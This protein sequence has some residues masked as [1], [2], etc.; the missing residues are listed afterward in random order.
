MPH[1]VS[2]TDRPAAPDPFG[3]VGRLLFRDDDVIVLDKPV[4]VAVHKGPKGGEVLED[5]FASLRFGRTNPPS[6][7]HRLDKDTSGCLV[8][9]RHRQALAMLGRL[10]ATG[11]VG[12]RYW[13]V[14]R[15]GPDADS[16]EIDAPLAKRDEKRGWFMMVDAGGQPSRT[17]WRVLGRGPGIAWLELVPF[18]GRTHQLRVHTAHAGF[19]ILGDPVYG[20]SPVNGPRLQLHAR[21]IALPAR[22]RRAAVAVTAP[23]PP[24]MLAALQACGFEGDGGGGRDGSGAA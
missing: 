24:H 6:L 22:G 11:A 18:T 10:F 3:L 14:V 19:P 13:A 16:G 4:G 9:G 17:G 8:L 20:R 12:K 7:A 1:P 2:A 21:S 5:G 15:G 23:V